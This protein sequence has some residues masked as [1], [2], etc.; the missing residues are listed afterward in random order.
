VRGRLAKGDILE[1]H[2]PVRTFAQGTINPASLPGYHTLRHGP[3][4]LARAGKEELAVARDAQLVREAETAFRVAGT[5]VVLSPIH[6]R[7]DLTKEDSW[8]Q[9]LFRD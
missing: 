9:V 2:L 1:F 4:V 8:L 7:F 6:S 5:D 3:M